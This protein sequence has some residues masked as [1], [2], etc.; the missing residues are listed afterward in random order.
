M[1]ITGLE[2]K[3]AELKSD[4]ADCVRRKASIGTQ[5]AY[6]EEKLAMLGNA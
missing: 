6:V 2:K 3:L 4:L 5:M 1:I